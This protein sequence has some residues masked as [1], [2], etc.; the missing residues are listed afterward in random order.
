[1]EGD[2]EAAKAEL[3]KAVKLLETALESNMKMHGGLA[4]DTIVNQEYLAD[5]YAALGN[6]G[7]ASNGYMAVITMVESL[8]G[9]EDPRIASVKQKMNFKEE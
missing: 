2:R 3:E 4:I 1:M 8:L 9:T 6:Y 5:A 7:E